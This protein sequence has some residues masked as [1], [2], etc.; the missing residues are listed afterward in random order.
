MKMAVC[1]P[2]PIIIRVILYKDDLMSGAGSTHER[3][4]ICITRKV[5]NNP[6]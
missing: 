6:E 1:C 2:L 5:H 3:N 4:D